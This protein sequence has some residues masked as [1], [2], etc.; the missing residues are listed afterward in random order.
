MP[1]PWFRDSVTRVR[2][3]LVTNPY[4]DPVR[5]WASAVRTTL[6]GWRVQPVQGSRQT[7][8]ETIPRDGLERNR[9]AFGPI[10]ADIE[11]TDRIEWAG[12]TWVIDGDVDR[13][14]GPTGRLAH[15]E[16]LLTRME[17]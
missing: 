12:V 6:T 17:G 10:G 11:T 9:R 13:W 7:A 14:R 4:G 1:F 15:T 16:I 3:P 5:D 2:A 8:A